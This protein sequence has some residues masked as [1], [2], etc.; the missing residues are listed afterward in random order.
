[1]INI[2]RLRTYSLSLD[3]L[4]VSLYIILTTKGVSLQ[5]L[6]LHQ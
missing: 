6:S 2:T 4:G 1:M 5:Y 3:P